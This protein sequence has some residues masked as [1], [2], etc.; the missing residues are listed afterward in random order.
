[1]SLYSS[2][3]FRQM[4]LLIH[5]IHARCGSLTECNSR[6]FRQM[7]LLIHMISARWLSYIIHVISARWLT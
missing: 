2:T 4:Y 6:D 7:A 3:D 5:V 1:M